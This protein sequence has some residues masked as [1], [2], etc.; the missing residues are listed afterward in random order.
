M[1]RRTGSGEQL[2]TSVTRR[3]AADFFLQVFDTRT[4]VVRMTKQLRRVG[5]D[6]YVRMLFRQLPGAVWTTDRNLYLTYVTGRLA[7]NVSPRATA[8]MSVYDVVGTRN[9]DHPVIVHHFA[10]ISGEPQSFE[11]E[12]GGR[13]Y[14]VFIEQ[15]VDDGGQVAGSIGAAVDITEQR[16]IQQRLARSEALLAQAQRVA[17]IG[18]FDWDMTS[19][20]LTWSDEMYRIYGLER[21]HFGSTFE[22]F[23]EHVYADDLELTK[24]VI[25]DAVR[26]HAPFVYEH[27]IVRSDGRVGVL[28]TRG[29][30]ITDHDRTV[31]VAGSCWDVTELREA[32][33][34]AQ[35]ARSLLEAALEATADGLL[36]IDRDGRVTAYNQRFLALW[37]VPK[38]LAAEQDHEKLLAY[39]RDEVEDPDTFLYRTQEIYRHPE[40]ESFDMLRFRD[41]RVFERYSRPQRIGEQIVGRVWSF[42]DVTEHQKL[43]RR[44]LFLADAARLL[45]S[46]DIEAALDSVAHLAVPFMGDG[47]VID[48]LG[49]GEP[50]RV[51]FVSRDCTESF[52][53]EL[54]SAVMAG[55][56]TIYP[57]NMRSCMAVP[58][59]MKDAVAGAISFIGPP[60]RSYD[61]S[62]LEFAEIIGRRVALSV[63]NAHLY[64]QTQEALESRDQLLTIAAHEIRG[65]ITSVHMA[66]QG[67]QK[68]N[69]PP[70]STAKLL[71][72]IEREDRRLARF[73]DELLELAKIQSGRMYFNFEE[74]DH[75]TG[76][77]RRPV[78]QVRA[79]PGSHE[80]SIKRDQVRRGEAY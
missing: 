28:H 38:D 64:R 33:D 7:N 78:G 13:W 74:V 67:L 12:A 48:L 43:L 1:V 44:A 46:L 3:Q 70:S 30:V 75:N 8:G 25:F 71:E 18:S 6:R 50:R 40:R 32:M 56:S 76:Q 51:A 17:H 19:N 66:V 57:L 35:R 4:G 77:A 79:E 72:I 41:G 59:V 5:H 68:G 31:R 9:P 21:G 80:P 24:S 22:A 58:L 65:P 55:H 52:S 39:A 10:A 26:N 60:M 23:L 27:R 14:A 54:P 36:V 61:N 11:Y 47:C 29:D 69:L 63:E 34:G 15:F 2:A 42:R 73:V 16:V 45:S 20:V 53:P 37:M 49:T 62:D